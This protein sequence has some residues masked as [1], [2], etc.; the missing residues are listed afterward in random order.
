MI[1][2]R[3]GKNA[4][5]LLFSREKN[6]EREIW[7]GFRYGPTAA[8]ETFSFDEAWPIGEFEQKLPELLANHPTLHFALGQNAVWDAK[9]S[10][11]REFLHGQSR[12]GKQAPT[13]I[14]DLRA[15]LDSW[16]LVKD[17]HEIALMRGAAAITSAAHARQPS[18]PGRIRPGG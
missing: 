13:Q 4:R 18:R 2:L 16:R 14:N 9:I 6:V 5:A 8:C 11:A 12:T 1:V 3:G 10:K 7:D 15:L 17:T